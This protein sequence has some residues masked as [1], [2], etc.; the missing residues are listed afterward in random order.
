MFQNGYCS[1]VWD[2]GGVIIITVVLGPLTDIRFVAGFMGAVEF[3]KELRD[4]PL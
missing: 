3:T 1:F 4:S 2:G